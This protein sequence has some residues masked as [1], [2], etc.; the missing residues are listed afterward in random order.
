MEIVQPLIDLAVGVGSMSAIQVPPQDYICLAAELALALG[1]ARPP[2]LS[3][4]YAV[5]RTIQ[6]SSARTFFCHFGPGAASEI[7]SN[8]SR[9]SGPLRRLVFQ[10]GLSVGMFKEK[11]AHFARRIGATRVGI[12]A[13]WASPDPRMAGAMG[14][15]ILKYAMSVYIAE[16]RTAV[17]MTARHPP[18][19]VVVCNIA[20]DAPNC[21]KTSS[22]LHGSTVL[23]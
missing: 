5:I 14:D 3:F 11:A 6:A 17:G 4:S 21:V 13:G 22:P 1:Q 20:I 12:N 7:A 18:D 15:P 8:C 23:S 16:T 19:S 10:P 9:M 2:H